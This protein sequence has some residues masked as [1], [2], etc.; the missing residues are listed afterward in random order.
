[1]YNININDNRNCIMGKTI[2]FIVFYID[3]PFLYYIEC[4]PIGF[5]PIS[6]NSVRFN[7]IKTH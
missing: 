1:M 5:I 7:C 3:N 6:T 4:L 2:A